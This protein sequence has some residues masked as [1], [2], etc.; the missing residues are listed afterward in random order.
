M[1]TLGIYPIYWLVST[2][3]EMNSLGADVPTVWI[4]II[5]FAGIYWLFKYSQ[6]FGRVVKRDNNTALWFVLYLF[7]GFIMPAIVQ[8]SL[9]NLATGQRG[10]A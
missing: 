8:S 10:A 4:L 9:N 3:N 1:F 6:A 5:P 2:K 7:L